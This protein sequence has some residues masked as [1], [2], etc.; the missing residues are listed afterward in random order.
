M[1]ANKAG[2]ESSGTSNIQETDKRAY[3]QMQY[4]LQREY[5]DALRRGGGSKAGLG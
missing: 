1:G 5:E 4:K 2:N 3:D